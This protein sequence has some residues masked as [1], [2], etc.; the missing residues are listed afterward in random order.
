VSQ[1]L[2]PGAVRRNI[3]VNGLRFSAWRT[4]PPN[5]ASDS[6]GTPVILLHGV[7]ETAAMWRD[8][9]PELGTDRI[10][11][12]PDLP[13]LG[14]SEVR[15]PYDMWTVAERVAALALH[16]V[17]GPVDVVG[18]DWG[19]T[20]ALALAS[21]RPDLVRRLVVVNAAYRWID[22]RAAW[23]VPLANVPVVPEL[24]FRVRGRALVRQ[25]IEYGWRSERGVDDDLVAHYQRAYADS[26]RVSAMLGYY[27]DNVRSRAAAGLRAWVQ[28]RGVRAR[29]RRDSARR[30]V[31]APALVVWG[32]RDPVLTDAVRASVVR[33]LGDCR[34]VIVPAAGHFVIEEAPETTIPAICSFLRQHDGE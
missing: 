19:G 3:A 28:R 2:V 20:A 9:L 24:V 11:L 12:A 18:H 23:H 6:T 13:G 30:T 4:E 31:S 10:V 26:E 14:S 34:C 5:A 8:L 22:L 27:R 1:D 17:D 15:G 21:S 32:T 29:A 25:M 7:P 16:E 33:D